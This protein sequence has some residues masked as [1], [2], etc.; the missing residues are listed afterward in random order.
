MEKTK[1]E[2]VYSSVQVKKSIL[3]R[4]RAIVEDE[5]EAPDYP[6]MAKPLTVSWWIN[7]TLEKG[8]D[9]VDLE[10]K[11]AAD[12]EKTEKSIQEKETENAEVDPRSC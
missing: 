6:P 11:E 12:H 9:R 2:S 7:Q 4:I 1:K 3:S 5:N 8:L 10:N